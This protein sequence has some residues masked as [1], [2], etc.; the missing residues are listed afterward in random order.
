MSQ[1]TFDEWEQCVR[2]KVQGTWNLHQATSSSK[3]DF[4]LLFSSICG[5]TGQWGQANYNAANSFL[6]A[7]VSYRH[8]QN[9][10]ASVVDIGFMGSIGM[11]IEN[12]S[13]EETL[14]AGGYYFLDEQDLID[15]LTIAIA[16]SRP[17]KDRFANKS[18][19]GLGIRSTKPITT[20]SARVVWKKDARMVFSHQLGS[21]GVVTDDVAR[22]SLRVAYQD[23]QNSD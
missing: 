3:L 18:Q 16:N 22:E 21:L 1:M 10:P 7:F 15:A 23:Q 11:A 13:L 8:H 20:P 5:L 19:L 2:P 9:L 14:K 12:S 4:F 17:G 6:D